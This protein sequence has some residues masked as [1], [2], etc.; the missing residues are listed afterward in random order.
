MAISAP[1]VLVTGASGFIGRHLVARLLASGKRVIAF[2][3]PSSQLPDWPNSVQIVR[4][5]LLDA[6]A[7]R[8]AAHG[9]GCVLHVG[10]IASARCGPDE[11]FRVNALGT[12]N[13]LE[14]S[15]L[16][17]VARFVLVSSAHVYGRALRLP[18]DEDHPLD[19]IS[20]YA[21][22]KAA[23]EHLARSYFKTYGLGV[24]I[25]RLFN[26]YGP[27]Q[28]AEAVVAG[29]V[30]QAAAGSRIAVLDGGVRR[31]FVFVEDVVDAILKAAKE[32]GAVGGIFNIGSGEDVAIADIVR[33][34]EV[35]SG[36]ES[37]AQNRGE[38]ASG[39]DRMICD[40]RRAAESLGWRPRTSLD[41]GLA[42]TYAAA[43][44]DYR[45]GEG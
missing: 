16:A 45:R 8:Q 23:A 13:V 6:D 35:L 41:R 22:A 5:D 19:P 9:A 33:K 26:C 17:G 2:V 32:P 14:A 3:R 31:D 29:V 30:A 24:A 10:G 39:G 12:L 27:G 7:I 36:V 44:N 42:A 18:V 40:N 38:S 28:S 4:G 43:S 1:A 37:S 11:V 15:R 25:L 20:P 21:A 34:I